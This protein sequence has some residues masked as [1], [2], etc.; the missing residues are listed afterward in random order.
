MMPNR[1]VEGAAAQDGLGTTALSAGDV[2]G[3]GYSDVIIGAPAADPGGRMNAGVLQ[4]F[5]GSATG[6]PAMP[7]RTLEGTP[8]NGGFG[9]S[10]A[11][12]GDTNGDGFA[13]VA[14]G[15]NYAP[16]GML[17]RAGNASVFNGSAMGLPMMPTRVLVG[18]ANLEE[19]G[20]AMAGIGDV[21]G[22]G[23]GDMAV[24]SN[25]A[26]GNA[27]NVSVFQGSAMGLPMMAAR[28]LEGQNQV[29]LFGTFLAQLQRVPSRRSR[30]FSLMVLS[31]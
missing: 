25:G 10:V 28:V 31:K 2:N 29:E 11:A 16:N 15:F 12:A 1:L 4:V 22:D 14:V 6:V 17:T 30:A 18:S 7:S 3:D 24:T 13:D 20:A 8:M 27:R 26:R 19:F 9:Y 21:N 23:F 5:H